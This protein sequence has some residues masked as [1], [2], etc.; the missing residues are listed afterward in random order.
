[1]SPQLQVVTVQ[2]L[3]QLPSWYVKKGPQT[4]WPPSQTSLAPQVPH[5]PPQPSSPHT[6]PVQSGT[7]TQIP[8]SHSC[9]GGHSPQQ[10]LSGMQPL[11]QLL[12][13]GWQAG[14]TPFSGRTAP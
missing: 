8:L 2:G 10:A 6:A 11:P 9:W 14:Q 12:K 1:M 3:T 13:S 5:V 7:Q 4:H